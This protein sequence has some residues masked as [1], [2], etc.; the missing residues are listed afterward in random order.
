MRLLKPFDPLCVWLCS[1][2]LSAPCSGL[3]LTE[4]WQTAKSS[5]QIQLQQILH[6]RCEA[7]ESNFCAA[8]CSS[9]GHCS[10]VMTPCQSC[11]D[12]SS[13]LLTTLLKHP[14]R[15][16]TFSH[17]RLNAED[18]AALWREEELVSL[19]PFGLIPEI[20]LVSHLWQRHLQAWCSDLGDP[21]G[22][23]SFLLTQD[24][25][26]FSASQGLLVCDNNAYQLN[27]EIEFKSHQF[28]H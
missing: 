28:P 7:V 26:G 6:L 3:E 27:F 10:W 11:F 2:F 1:L 19:I 13:A 20:F 15:L 17:R 21:A 9:S 5:G 18:L 14:E 24:G 25:F 16:S 23:P 12:E 22:N 4:Q 8:L